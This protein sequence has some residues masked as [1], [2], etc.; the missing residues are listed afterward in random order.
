MS[1]IAD[2]LAG[3]VTN[4]E[5]KQI[6]FTATA[7]QVASIDSAYRR[8]GYDNRSDFLNDCAMDAVEQVDASQKLKQ[9]AAEAA[10]L[11]DGGD[12][13]GDEEGAG[14]GSE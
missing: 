6:S 4:A 7:D 8:A 11:A 14:G 9:E 12:G 3:K 2:R 5:S 10:A 13:A 1:R